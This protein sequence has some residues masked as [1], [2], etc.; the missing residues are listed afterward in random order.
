MIELRHPLA[1]LATRLPWAALERALT[2]TAEASPFPVST[3]TAEDP[4]GTHERPVGGG[5]SAAGRPRSTPERV[6][7]APGWPSSALGRW[8]EPVAAIAG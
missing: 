3:E 5:D 4:F 2:P 6:K 1:V 7:L 8:R